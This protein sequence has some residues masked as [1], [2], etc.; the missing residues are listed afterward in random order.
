[1]RRVRRGCIGN[2]GF[3]T[4]LNLW[5]NLELAVRSGNDANYAAGAES[6]SFVWQHATLTATGQ[7]R[8]LRDCDEAVC[9]LFWEFGAAR[10]ITDAPPFAD[11]AMDHVPARFL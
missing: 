5:N 8:G 10:P 1:M 11:R 6:V 2:A 4:V 3:A 7:D 9:I